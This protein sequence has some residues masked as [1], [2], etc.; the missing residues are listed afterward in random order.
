MLRLSGS[1]ETFVFLVGGFLLVISSP[2][3]G[4]C[5]RFSQLLLNVCFARYICLNSSDPFSMDVCGV[6]CSERN[7]SFYLNTLS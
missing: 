7:E 3:N 6:L 5:Y 4:E 2:S 1:F